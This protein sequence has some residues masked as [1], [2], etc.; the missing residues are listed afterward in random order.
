MRSTTFG[1]YLPQGRLFLPPRR[2]YVRISV[3]STVV[4][5][6]GP[7]MEPD[8]FDSLVDAIYYGG[9]YEKAKLD[10]HATDGKSPNNDWTNDLLLR[11]FN[12]LTDT[13]SPNERDSIG[14]NATVI[15]LL[16]ALVALAIALLSIVLS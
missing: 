2:H 15:G 1:L 3:P 9:L 8:L 13:T 7:H 4:Y 12:I 11:V 16:V 5:V 10:F 14:V 6:D